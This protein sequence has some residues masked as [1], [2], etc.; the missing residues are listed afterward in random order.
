LK[1]IDR[2]FIAVRKDVFTV[3]L[4]TVSPAF[5]ALTNVFLSYTLLMAFNAFISDYALHVEDADN[6]MKRL[7]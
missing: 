4:R 3:N 5:I 6:L 7:S 1:T 2:N